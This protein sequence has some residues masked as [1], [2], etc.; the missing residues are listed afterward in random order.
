MIEQTDAFPLLVGACPSFEDRWLEHLRENGNDLPYIAA[1]SFADHLLSLQ[2][3]DDQSS[4]PAVAAAI[5]RL[6]TE[7]SPWVKEFATIGILEGIQ[8]VWSN[9]S[10][11]PEVFGTFLFPESQSWW[12]GLKNFWSGNAPLVT[13]D[14]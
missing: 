3:A 9:N 8:N 11:D 4:F 12:R 13:R 2:Q 6:H 5:E 10:C 1:G 14:A 7:G